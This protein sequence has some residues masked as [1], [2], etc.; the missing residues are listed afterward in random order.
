MMVCEKPVVRGPRKGKS[1]TGTTTGYGRHLRAGEPACEDCRHGHRLRQ[2]RWSEKNPGYMTAYR[3]KWRAEHLRWEQESTL[4]RQFD[5]SLAHFDDL[6]A[7]QGHTCAICGTSEPGG[8][9][10]WHLDHD[11][12]CCPSNPS[13]GECVRGI[14]CMRCN[15]SLG[16]FEDDPQRLR[17]AIAYLQTS[18]SQPLEPNDD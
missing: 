8:K 10:Y 4:R 15:V 17:A 2:R 11:H 1:A 13:C 14:L 18:N 3:R 9:G 6:L 5:I 16:G 12:R 7:S